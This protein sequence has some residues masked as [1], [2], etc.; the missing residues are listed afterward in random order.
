M[1]DEY[2]LET[3]G[4]VPDLVMVGK[5]FRYNKKSKDLGLNLGAPHM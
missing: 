5:S 1:I 4:V 3:Y 2:R